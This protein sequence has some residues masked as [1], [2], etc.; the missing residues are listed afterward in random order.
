MPC[1]SRTKTVQGEV[2]MFTWLVR[3]IMLA[4]VLL[5][6]SGCSTILP[7]RKVP[8]ESPKILEEDVP[9]SG[10]V[11]PKSDDDQAPS[12]LEGPASPPAEYV[13]PGSRP[14][15]RLPFKDRRLERGMNFPGTRE[16]YSA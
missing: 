2:F 11:R 13:P 1:P 15:R 7:E 6:I 3:S 16:P 5:W 8:A 10:S 9:D 4:T 14:P 12:N